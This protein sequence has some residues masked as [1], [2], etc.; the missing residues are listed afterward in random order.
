MSSINYKKI[1]NSL[2]K[3]K[4]AVHVR[5]RGKKEY[6]AGTH[7]NETKILKNIETCIQMIEHYLKKN[8]KK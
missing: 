2:E 8:L 4:Q 7:K 5:K 6:V 1:D 3:S